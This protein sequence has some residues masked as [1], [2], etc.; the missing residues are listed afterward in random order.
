LIPRELSIEYSALE[1]GLGCLVR[2]DRKQ[3]FIGNQA[4]IDWQ[5]R[6]SKET[7]LHEFGAELEIEILG[8]CLKQR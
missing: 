6:S 8:V 5:A 3:D 2:L 1:S 4:L 7:G